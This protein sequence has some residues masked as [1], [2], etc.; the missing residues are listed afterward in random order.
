MSATTSTGGTRPPE[1]R[2]P[3]AISVTK[4]TDLTSPILL[5]RC[6]M[7]K[8][9]PKAKLEFMRAD[10]DG[11]PV[12]YYQVGLEN[13]MTANIRQMVGG[14][15]I[16]HDDFGLRFAKIKWTYTHQK[17]G[18]GSGGSTAGS[19]GL[20][21]KKVAARRS[22]RVDDNSL[23]PATMLTAFFHASPGAD[24]LRLVRVRK[25]PKKPAKAPTN[26]RIRS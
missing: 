4:F 15:S 18:G 24:G 1:R 25:P 23:P 11:N 22:C 20:A 26:K 19:W 16:L 6:S 10:S 2:D 17:I 14:S 5:P 12:K 9:I 21:A 3:S 7:G 13:V 8:T